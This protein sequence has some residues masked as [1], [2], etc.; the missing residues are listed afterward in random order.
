MKVT[1]RK[2]LAVVWAG[3]IGGAVALLLFLAWL[4]D[5]ALEGE[6]LVFD[7]WASANLQRHASATLT[8]VMLAITTMGSTLVLIGLLVITLLYLLWVGRRRGSLVLAVTMAGA[9]ILN[10]IL[11][12]SFRRTRPEPLFGLISPSSFSFPSGHALLSFSFY[13]AVA[14][15]LTANLRNQM[16]RVAIWLVASLFV[17]TIGLS[18]V[19]LGMHYASDVVAGYTA[20]LIWLLT[21]SFVYSKRRGGK[22]NAE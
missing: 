20:A 18:R 4:A 1:F 19:Y 21:V 3:G 14:L 16:Q 12:L 13:G 6:T 9:F 15:L 5:E 8:S 17:L 2:W 7:N 22:R 11:K 10:A